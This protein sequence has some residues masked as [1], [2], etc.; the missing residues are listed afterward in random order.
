[1]T[2]IPLSLFHGRR[3]GWVWCWVWAPVQTDKG[4]R[5]FRA[6]GGPTPS[7]SGEIQEEEHTPCTN[8][9][10][11]AVGLAVFEEVIGN[12]TQLGRNKEL[13]TGRLAL[14]ARS[15]NVPGYGSV[16]LSFSLCLSRVQLMT[17]AML[18]TEVCLE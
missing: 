14:I 2:S 10:C 4:R 6:V 12:P 15:S 13:S 5:F 11:L 1:M 18:C 8:K 3:L 17:L 7:W 9:V 16:S